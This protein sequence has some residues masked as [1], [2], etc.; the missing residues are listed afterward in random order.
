MDNEQQDGLGGGGIWGGRPASSHRR[1]LHNVAL[2]A[3][4]VATLIA[5]GARLI[6]HLPGPNRTLE[7]HGL[8][9]EIVALTESMRAVADHLRA[10]AGQ[11]PAGRRMGF[12]Y[13]VRRG[14]MR[15]LRE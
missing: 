1:N 9:D 5:E 8:C 13:A 14:F 15:W 12:W 11:V 4:R 7:I 3:S 10:E 2:E 6:D